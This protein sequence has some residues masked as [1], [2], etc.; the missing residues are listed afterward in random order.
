MVVLRIWYPLRPD[1][2]NPGFASL[3][4]SS[5]KRAAYMSVRPVKDSTN[6]GPEAMTATLADDVKAEGRDTP[7]LWT[8]TRMDEARILRA[9]DQFKGPLAL[10]SKTRKRENSFRVCDMLLAIGRGYQADGGLHRAGTLTDQA[11]APIRFAGLALNRIALSA[12]AERYLKFEH[13]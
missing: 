8:Y 2:P 13:W 6:R 4:V 11:E 7:Y 10:H 3:Y 9:W 12:N 5:A 1:G